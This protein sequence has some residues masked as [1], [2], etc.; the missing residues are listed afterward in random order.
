MK[1]IWKKTSRRRRYGGGVQEKEKERSTEW[2]DRWL[3]AARR[4]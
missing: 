4:R 2:I 3:A 1:N